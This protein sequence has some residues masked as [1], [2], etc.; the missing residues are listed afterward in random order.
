MY[1]YCTIY[2]N[3]HMF[4][5]VQIKFVY[6]DLKARG[7]PARLLLAYAGVD[8]EVKPGEPHSVSSKDDI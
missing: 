4:S 7:E 2:D 5:A 8:Y 6:F 3:Y 1:S